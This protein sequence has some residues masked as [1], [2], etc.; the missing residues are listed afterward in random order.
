MLGREG[1]DYHFE[2]TYC[3]AH[4]VKSE[5]VPEIRTVG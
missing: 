1:M 4:P 3:R 5:V 2:F